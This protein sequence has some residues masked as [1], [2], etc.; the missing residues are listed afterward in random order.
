[1]TKYEQIKQRKNRK[2]NTCDVCSVCLQPNKCVVSIG[3]C[4]HYHVYKIKRGQKLV[5]HVYSFHCAG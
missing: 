5:C 3:P 4:V 2:R 1:M